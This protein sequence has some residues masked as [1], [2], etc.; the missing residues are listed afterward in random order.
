MEDHYAESSGDVASAGGKGVPEAIRAAAADA[1]KPS[2]CAGTI[3]IKGKSLYALKVNCY[4]FVATIRI[5]GKRH[6][7]CP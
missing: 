4:R 1:Q 5:K 7:C 6:R 3:R 2:L